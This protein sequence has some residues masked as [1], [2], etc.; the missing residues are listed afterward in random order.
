MQARVAAVRARVEAACGRAG[1]DPAS[2]T[3]IA[4]SKTQPAASIVEAAAAGVTDFGENYAQEAFAKL[5]DAD[6]AR[7]PLTWHFIGHLQSNKTPAV[8]RRFPWIHTI[9]SER[10]LAAVARVAADA[11]LRLRLLLQVNTS[12]EVTK[13]GVAED[14]LP[15]LV[16]LARTFGSLELAGLMTIPAPCSDP[17]ASRPAFRR[18]CALVETHGLACRSMGMTGDF[19]VAIEEGA[20]HIRVGRAIFGERPR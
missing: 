3:L 4:V 6:I 19:E 7:L 10:Q 18:L 2:V 13:G 1:R 5:E 16:R 8:A 11:R 15:E 17:E 20:T 9:D 14:A 12:G